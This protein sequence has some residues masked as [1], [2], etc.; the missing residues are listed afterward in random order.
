MAEGK[1]PKKPGY[2]NVLEVCRKEFRHFKKDDGNT[3]IHDF[4][5]RIENLAKVG[6]PDEVLIA[7][8]ENLE[9]VRKFL[10]EGKDEIAFSIFFRTFPSCLPHRSRRI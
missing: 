1:F 3:L 7:Q 4:H 10:K 2:G 5:S 6:L 9:N 8:K